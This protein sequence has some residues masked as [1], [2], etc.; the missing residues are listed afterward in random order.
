MIF[1]RNL[2]TGKESLDAQGETGLFM[3]VEFA[4]GLFERCFSCFLKVISIR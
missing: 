2:L 3:F 4:S 1:M